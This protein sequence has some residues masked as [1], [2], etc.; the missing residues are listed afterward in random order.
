MSSCVASFLVLFWFFLSLLINL[1]SHPPSQTLHC[2]NIILY[3]NLTC[4]FSLSFTLMWFVLYR[5]D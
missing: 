1:A 5:Y 3:K 4:S 2:I